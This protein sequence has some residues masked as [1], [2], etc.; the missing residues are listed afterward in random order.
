[1]ADCTIPMFRNG[2]VRTTYVDTP[3][4]QRDARRLQKFYQTS[5]KQGAFLAFV[6]IVDAV[7]DTSSSSKLLHVFPDRFLP[8]KLHGVASRSLAY[9][10]CIPGVRAPE[11]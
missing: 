11:S 5:G 6:L 1:M 4:Y 8:I 9:S 3:R 7:L 10:R 2:T